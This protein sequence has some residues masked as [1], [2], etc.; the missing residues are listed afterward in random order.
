MKREVRLTTHDPLSLGGIQSD[1]E[2]EIF[3]LGN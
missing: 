2:D 1:I 3:Q